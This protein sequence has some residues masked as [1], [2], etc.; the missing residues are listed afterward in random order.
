M[1]QL[2]TSGL[3]QRD[4]ASAPR[5]RIALLEDCAAEAQALTDLLEANGCDV[6]L[7]TTGAAFLQMLLRETFDLL[8]LDW[9]LP[10]M[11]GFEVLRK[12]RGGSF[13]LN[14]P[15]LMLTARFGEFETVQALEGGADD[16]LA[17]P[18][19]PFELIARIKVLLRPAHDLSQETTKELH[20]FVF[21]RW[22]WTVH[23]HGQRVVLTPREFAMAQMMF[24]YMG[25]PVSRAHL[26][27]TVWRGEGTM[28]RSVDTHVSR[29]R[30]KLGLTLENGFS[31]QSIHGV[32]YRL[33]RVDAR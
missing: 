32:G 24:Q 2:T 20:G 18:W 21:D 11:T 23:C 17:K 13:S 4:G 29:L 16:Y 31:L 14:V 6:T 5:T 10:D 3:I 25:C 26:F 30:S 22:T 1:N 15:V 9:V 12:V 27:Q 8:V 19:R 7:Q 28:G 33:D